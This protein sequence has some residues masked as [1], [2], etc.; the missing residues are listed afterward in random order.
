M[1]FVLGAFAVVVGSGLIV[2]QRREDRQKERAFE[3]LIAFPGR[4]VA[5][6]G[7]AR[8]PRD[9]SHPGVGGV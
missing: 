3:D 1:A 9:R 7:G 4:A 2:V 6:D 5:A 8:S